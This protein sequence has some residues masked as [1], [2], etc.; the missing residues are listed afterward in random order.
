MIDIEFY[1]LSNIHGGYCNYGMFVQG[2]DFFFF[3]I[4][5]SVLLVASCACCFCSGTS[6]DTAGKALV[7]FGL[8]GSIV[9]YTVGAPLLF[10]HTDIYSCYN[11]TSIGGISRSS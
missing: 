6:D 9:G 3:G 1:E 8:V 4:A 11:V 10:L 2:M 7:A 5:N